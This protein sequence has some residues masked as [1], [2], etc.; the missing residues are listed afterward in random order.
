MMI[1]ETRKKLFFIK[2]KKVTKKKELNYPRLT[3]LAQD[4]GYEIEITSWKKQ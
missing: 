3:C 1:R 4:Q 2:K